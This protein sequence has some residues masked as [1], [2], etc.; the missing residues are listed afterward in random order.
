MQQDLEPLI[1]AGQLLLY[2]AKN[3]EAEGRLDEARSLYLKAIAQGFL[4][5][6]LRMTGEWAITED[7]AQTLLD[8][9]LPYPNLILEGVS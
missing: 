7:R 1:L 8:Q 9:G 2:L 3:Y 5:R 4:I 6:R